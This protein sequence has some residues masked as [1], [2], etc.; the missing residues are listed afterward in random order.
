MQEAFCLYNSYGHLTLFNN[1]QN[2]AKANIQ[3]NQCWIWISSDNHCCWLNP[4]GMEFGKHPYHGNYNNDPWGLQVSINQRPK[5]MICPT[6]FCHG[7]FGYLCPSDTVLI[8]GWTGRT[9][10]L[11]CSITKMETS[12]FS[13]TSSRKDHRRIVS[14]LI[15]SFE[16]VWLVWWI[17]IAIIAITL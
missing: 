5:T 13:D 17:F 15:F 7:V 9:V 11:K 10:P 8:I 16:H 1:P 12:Y 3:H 6:Y 14:D 4:W 2:G